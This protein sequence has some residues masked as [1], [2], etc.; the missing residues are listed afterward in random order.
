M[1]EGAAELTKMEAKWY[2]FKETQLTKREER[3]LPRSAY[4]PIS[5]N[6]TK[7]STEQLEPTIQDLFTKPKIEAVE[8]VQTEDQQ[9]DISIIELN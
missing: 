1:E 5:T 4:E 2:Q 7:I 6:D 9:Q 3:M 8:S